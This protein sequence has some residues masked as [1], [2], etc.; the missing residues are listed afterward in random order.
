MDRRSGCQGQ[1]D[2][3]SGVAVPTPEAAC[4]A[5]GE[6]NIL[7]SSE[8]RRDRFENTEVDRD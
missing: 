3:A 1:R 7:F 4:L 2:K 5:K 8:E 6:N